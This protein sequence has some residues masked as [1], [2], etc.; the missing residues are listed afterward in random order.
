M[1]SG[2]WEAGWGWGRGEGCVRL[3]QGVLSFLPDLKGQQVVPTPW[4][5][6]VPGPAVCGYL[7]KALRSCVLSWGGGPGM[8]SLR[9]SHCRSAHACPPQ[10]SGQWAGPAH[11]G[12]VG[13]GPS[14]QHQGCWPPQH[15]PRGTPVSNC[16]QQPLPSTASG[17]DVTTGCP[18]GAWEA[19]R[20][21]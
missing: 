20:R 11:H 5:T 18:Q 14:A 19:Q 17:Y 13:H 12:A 15:Q 2:R 3:S 21:A 7:Q 9:S 4:A 16:L 10:G 1:L 6:A 8:E